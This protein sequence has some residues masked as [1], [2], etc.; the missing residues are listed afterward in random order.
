M[1]GI[2]YAN[3]GSPGWLRLVPSADVSWFG[4][5]SYQRSSHDKQGFGAIQ[6]GKERGSFDGTVSMQHLPLCEHSTRFPCQKE[7]SGSAAIV[8]YL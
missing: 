3:L 1:S 5:L 7:Q 6:G 2:I 8:V 4:R